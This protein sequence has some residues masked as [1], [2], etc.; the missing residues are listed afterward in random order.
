V[1]GSR[2][3]VLTELLLLCLIGAGCT[4]RQRP[5]VGEIVQSGLC[6]QDVNG[7]YSQPQSTAGYATTGPLTLTD[8]TTEVPLRQGVAFGYVW[9]ASNLPNPAVIT[10]RVEHPAITRPDGVTMS[11]FEEDL[12]VE[13]LRGEYQTTDCY[14][15]SEKFELVPG[16]WTLSVLFRGTLLV[17]QSFHI[18]ELM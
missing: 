16:T 7:R 18:T 2:F 4:G 1:R 8:R 3:I 17:K 6:I 9:K 15:L 10:Y 11:R 12:V 5:A 14:A 13:T